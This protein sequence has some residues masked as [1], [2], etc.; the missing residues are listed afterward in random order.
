MKAYHDFII[1]S[2]TAFKETFT[3]EGGLEL[4]ADKR[5]SYDRLAN[6][7]AV[8]LEI[9]AKFDG[10]EIKPGYQVMIDPT[11]YYQQ[12][13]EHNGKQENT[14]MVD[15]HKGIYKCE[16]SM[17][18]L[19][20]ETPEENWKAY[21]DNLVI[22]CEKVTI[23]AV[24]LGNLQLEPERI[25]HKKGFGKV[26]YPTQHLLENEVNSGDEIAIKEEYAVPFWIEGKQYFWTNNRHVLAKIEV[27]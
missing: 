17:I 25:S 23:P 4:H 21:A 11:I 3:T 13:Y 1:Q 8:V 15:R 19:Y 27:N 6:R 9:P 14:Y 7:L 26:V 2:E 20:R 12:E 22:E 18:V 10:S 16:P 5:F 24:M